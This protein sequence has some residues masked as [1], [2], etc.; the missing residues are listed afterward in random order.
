MTDF[1][2]NVETLQLGTVNAYIIN[3]ERKILVDT[4]NPGGV[5]R[6]LARFRKYSIDPSEISLILLTHYH[7]DHTGNA[8]ELKDTLNVPVAIH[9]TEADGL[10]KGHAPAKPVTGFARFLARMT[11]RTKSPPCEADIL[12]SDGFSLNAYGV[13][14]KV[15]HTP[16]HSPGS[17]SVICKSG[18]ALT[19]DLVFGHLFLNRRKPAEP[20]FCDDQEQA[21]QSIRKLLSYEPAI[22]YP[23]HGGPFRSEDVAFKFG[24][25]T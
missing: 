21:R 15:I 13:E 9:E 2:P 17:C 12:L 20:M 8:A 24:I 6:I 25:H 11:E 10:S 16:G 7:A 19:G 22:I 5:K 1:S 3:G 4:G 18:E 14:A 23:G